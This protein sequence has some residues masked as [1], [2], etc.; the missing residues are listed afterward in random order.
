MTDT[1]RKPREWAID[2]IQCDPIEP[3][4]PSFYCA[5]ATWTPDDERNGRVRVREV[6][7]AEA[8]EQSDILGPG[9]RKAIEMLM[10][11]EAFEY[12][13]KCGN[14]EIIKGLII[15]PNKNDWANWLRDRAKA[16]GWLK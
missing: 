15:S 10:S 12:W 6:L 1:K 9:I 7:P 14:A 8:P 5:Y 4:L 11:K 13:R 2:K 16:E 3:T